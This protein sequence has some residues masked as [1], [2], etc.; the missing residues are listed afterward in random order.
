MVIWFWSRVAVG[1]M[2]SGLLSSGIIMQA[3][4]DMKAGKKYHCR[5]TATHPPTQLE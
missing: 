1:Q 5:E 2:T 4:M 3:H